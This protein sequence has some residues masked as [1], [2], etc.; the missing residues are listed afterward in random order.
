MLAIQAVTLVD[1]KAALVARVPAEDEATIACHAT[2]IVIGKAVVTVS[3]DES[4]VIAPHCLLKKPYPTD[5]NRI[6]VITRQM[7][8]A[9]CYR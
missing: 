3:V 2:D 6:A 1:D 4:R 8:R 7:L 9:D 5:V